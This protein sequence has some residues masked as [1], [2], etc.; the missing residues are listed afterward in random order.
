MTTTL[1]RLETERA[2]L[3]ETIAGIDD[4]AMT[5]EGTPGAW[6]VKD[7][8][9]R[10]AVWDRRGL[11]W[12]DEAVHGTVPHIPEPGLTFADMDRLNEQ[13][14]VEHRERPLV[15]VLA[16][17]RDASERLLARVRKLTPED[18]A[19]SF[20]LGQPDV[21]DPM[22]VERLVAWRWHHYAEHGY[23]IRRWIAQRRP[24]SSAAATR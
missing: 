18:L 10:I 14:F 20:S 12:I 7:L 16:E 8:V 5:E 24:D 1:S 4:A 23:E 3:D 9:A 6:S 13:T 2:L 19:R 17:Y 22:T 21:A 11:R 15:E